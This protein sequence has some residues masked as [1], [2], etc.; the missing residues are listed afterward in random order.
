M[1]AGLRVLLPLVLLP[2]ALLP[3]GATAGGAVGMFQSCINI[4]ITVLVL[5]ALINSHQKKQRLSKDAEHSSMGK[6]TDQ[7]TRKPTGSVAPAIPTR[8]NLQEYPSAL[9]TMTR[10]GGGG[11]AEPF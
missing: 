4:I 1:L 9:S 7:Q 5:A 2:L 3:L 6:V 8:P 11:L 10:S